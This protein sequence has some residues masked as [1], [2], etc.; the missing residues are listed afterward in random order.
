MLERTTRWLLCSQPETSHANN[1][2]LAQLMNFNLNTTLAVVF[3]LQQ[4]KCMRCGGAAAR[5]HVFARK[6]FIHWNTHET[7][8]VP[9]HKNNISIFVLAA[10]LLHNFTIVE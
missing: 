9:M 4:T 6:I 1:Q 2:K 10:S 7:N 3:V 8:V 5:R